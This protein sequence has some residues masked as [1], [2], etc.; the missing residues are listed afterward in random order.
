M[1]VNFMQP[2]R[3]SRIL[4]P[5][6]I[7]GTVVL[8]AASSIAGAVVAASVFSSKSPHTNFMSA[9]QALVAFAS[10]VSFLYIL[11]HFL[12]ALSNEAV[13]V[14]RPPEIR[15]HAFCFI[16]ARLAFVAWMIAVIASSITVSNASTCLKGSRD[17]KLQVLDV[18][19]STVA[20]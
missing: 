2:T 5:G 12:A 10:S 13:G 18:V 15:L 11:L 1:P 17:C 4:P 19:A 9:T 8:L 3:T 16:V 20:L 14:V 7:L 6:L